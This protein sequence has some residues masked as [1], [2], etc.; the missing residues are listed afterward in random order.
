MRLPRPGV[1]AFI[2]ANLRAAIPKHDPSGDQHRS[3]RMRMPGP[4]RAAGRGGSTRPV[5]D[6]GPARR[7][8]KPEARDRT[9]ACAPASKRCSITPRL[10][11]FRRV[12]IPPLGRGTSITFS[13]RSPRKSSPAPRGARLQLRS[14]AS[15]RELRGV[16][17]TIDSA[18]S[19]IHHLDCGSHQ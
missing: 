2:E 18:R 4:R 19:G 16:S 9:T 11:G 1:Q 12:K 8:G 10:A 7:S 17:H 15:W 14:A 13:R 6:E 3:T 5:G